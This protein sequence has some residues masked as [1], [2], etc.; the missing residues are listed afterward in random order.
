MLGPPPPPPGP[1]I[2]H[3]TPYRPGEVW[4]PADTFQH[5]ETCP[6]GNPLVGYSTLAQ[7]LGDERF[8]PAPN[9]APG[10][11]L[12][13][14][15]AARASIPVP[16]ITRRI[17]RDLGGGARASKSARARG[18]AGAGA[19]AG[20]ASG[21]ALARSNTGIGTEVD[22]QVGRAIGAGVF[23]EDAVTGFGG[24]AIAPDVDPWMGRFAAACV[25]SGIHGLAAQ[26][27]F[28][29]VA[30]AGGGGGANGPRQGPLAT[31]VDMVAV[32]PHDWTVE[33][34]NLAFDCPVDADGAPLDDA[35]VPFFSTPFTSSSSSA[36]T[37]KRRG[38]PTR[39]MRLFAS[40]LILADVSASSPWRRIAEGER[41]GGSVL[42]SKSP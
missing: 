35:F 32:V 20:R 38:P 24:G 16:G 23:T 7:A 15:G 39:G 27:V 22:T 25:A 17:A 11:R 40:Y 31:A 30:R 1:P 12:R 33:A 9:G 3:A 34:A 36:F 10:F 2:L 5:R 8:Q 29:R 14:E 21:G 4:A 28:G 13:L 6:F 18:R 19:G 37:T 41:A 26:V 42:V